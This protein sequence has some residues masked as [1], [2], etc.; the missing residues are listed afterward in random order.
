MMKKLMLGLRWERIRTVPGLSRNVVVLIALIVAGIAAGSYMGSQM[1]LIP[2]WDDRYTFSAEFEN[3][4][5]TQPEIIHTVTIA[6]VQVGQIV[7]WRVS[8][9]GT[10]IITMD[11][12]GEHQIYDN[13]RAVLRTVNPL[14]Q[15]FIEINPGGPPAEPLP[16]NRTIP[17]SQTERPIQ[18]NEVLQKLDQRAQHALTAMLQ[19]SDA[20]LA[21]APEQLPDGFRATDSF[22]K[23]LRPAVEA[24]Q[25]RREKLGQLMNSLSQLAAA[26]GGNQERVTR[27]ASATEQALGVVAR[28][29]RQLRQS[30]RQLPGLNHQLRRALTSTQGLTTQLDPTLDNL[31]AASEKLPPALER[32]TG[33]TKEL[34]RFVDKARPVVAEARPV[35]ADLRPL[36]TDVDHALDDT[37][38]VTDKLDRDTRIVTSY[39]TDLQ[40]FVFNTSS[41]FSV[42]DERG[43]IIRG[44]AIVPSDGGLV[45]GNNGGYD[46]GHDSGDNAE[47]GN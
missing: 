45:P 1:R 28:N 31:N 18:A 11:I 42:S 43:P 23:S 35:V 22:L 12:E 40:A 24:V 34:G 16:E 36:I 4:P 44:H 29:D 37:K 8:E 39:L 25:T 13:A 32:F 26:A 9:R 15:M 7:D 38:T 47:G 14:N 19:E 2:P 33:T 30:L 27:L 10:A 17:V 20:A 21:R 41:L 3:A 6:G 46:P 5:G